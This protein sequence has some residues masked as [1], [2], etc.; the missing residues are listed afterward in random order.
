[1]QELRHLLRVGPEPV[2]PDEID[3]VVTLKVS[4]VVNGEVQ[5]TNQVRNVTYPPDYLVGLHMKVVTHLPG[6][7]LSTGTRSA[8][9]IQDGDVVECH[10]D[11]FD[12]LVCPVRHLKV[13]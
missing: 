12:R 2:T 5:A 11:G 9:H 1:M 8:A 3:D 4:T 6:H 13:S 10:I 7:V